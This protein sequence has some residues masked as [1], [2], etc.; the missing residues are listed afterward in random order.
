MT[1]EEAL[2]GNNGKWGYLRE[3]QKIAD[4][5][6]SESPDPYGKRFGLE[7]YLAAIFGEDNSWNYH[8]KIK[9]DYVGIDGKTHHYLEP[10]YKR[11]NQVIEFDGTPHYKS[12]DKI[13]EDII[14]DD[15][16]Q[17][18][19]FDVIRIPYFIQLTN[20]VV[21]EIF[22]VEVEQPLFDSNQQSLNYS[23]NNTP[24]QIPITGVWRM[25]SEYL[26]YPHQYQVNIGYLERLNKPKSS[27]LDTL[28]QCYDFLEKNPSISY[29]DRI[30]DI[31]SRILK[32]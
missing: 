24:G 1:V 11:G 7:L 15:I 6:D 18:L 12:L 3:S 32:H 9:V 20:E 5:D 2:K 14:K 13:L 21:K 23:L 28:R 26:K 4:K 10:D 22:K 30:Y 17:K 19:G 16:Y 31:I 29:V 25:A 8:D 27:G